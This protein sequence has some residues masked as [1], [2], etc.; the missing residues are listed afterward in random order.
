MDHNSLNNDNNNV[1]SIMLSFGG[2][3]ALK[4]KNNL[5][6]Q[7]NGIRIDDDDSNSDNEIIGMDNRTLYARNNNSINLDDI[8]N[9]NDNVNNKRKIDNDT[10][11]PFDYLN[12][13]EVIKIQKQKQKKLKKYSDLDESEFGSQSE[14]E[15]ESEFEI[16]TSCSDISDTDDSNSDSDN[17]YNPIIKNLNKFEKSPSEILN[18]NHVNTTSSII[19]NDFIVDKDRKRLS[20]KRRRKRKRQSNF[21]CFGCTYGSPNQDPI[22]GENMNTLIRIFEE[23]YGKTDN[24]ILARMCHVYFKQHIWIPMKNRGFRIHMWRTRE[25]YIH[26]TKHLEEPRIYLV[27]TIK[28]YKNIAKVLECMV[29]KKYSDNGDLIIPDKRNLKDLLDVDKRII[30]LYKTKPQSMNFYNENSSIDLSQKGKLI[31]IQQNWV[32]N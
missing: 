19:Q 29:F 10:K 8:V 21:S 28:K 30:E 32:F 1:H 31:N 20:H 26:F 14:S 4:F 22:S 23:N 17:G 18:M 7:Q 27:E 24:F 16:E 12:S 15:S 2:K 6:Q 5:R 11:T 13:K 25:I 3:N 9:D